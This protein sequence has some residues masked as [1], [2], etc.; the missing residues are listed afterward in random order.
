MKKKYKTTDPCLAC[1]IVT[2]G[3]NCLHHVKT[4]GAGGCDC[5]YNLMPLC[6]QHHNEVH[7]SGLHDFAEKYLKVF[8]WL[9][10]YDWIFYELMWKWI[11]FPQEGD[12]CFC[13]TDA[14]N[15]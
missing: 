15:K 9:K 11:R 6:L 14:I 2:P 12:R 7:N 4:R 1:G 10:D 3:G 8:I 13:T 5:S